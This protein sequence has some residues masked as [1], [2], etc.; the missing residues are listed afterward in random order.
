MEKIENYIISNR[1]QKN[2]ILMGYVDN[3]L[4]FIK[5]AH[6]SILPSYSEGTSRFILE[7]LHS[8][9]KVIVRNTSGID[10]VLNKENAYLFNTDDQLKK[11]IRTLFNSKIFKKDP[12]KNY[13][14]IFDKNTNLHKIEEEIRTLINK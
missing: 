4:P 2:I 5:R 12:C 11:T 6:Y 7:S 9:K 14:K 1:L 3:V 10:E 13:P 8:G